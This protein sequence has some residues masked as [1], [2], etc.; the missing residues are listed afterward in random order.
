MSVEVRSILHDS[1]RDRWVRVEARI[2][3]G[4]SLNW[5]ILSGMVLKA[6][7]LY[8]ITREFNGR[9]ILPEEYSNPIRIAIRT[10]YG[11]LILSAK[12]FYSDWIIDEVYVIV[13]L[14]IIDNKCTS[15]GICNSSPI[16]VI[17]KIVPL[18][19]QKA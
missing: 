10:V 4:Q 11:R 7:D 6:T 12:K 14:V 3:V 5:L 15:V 16:E 9:E 19:A 1:V 17:I 18:D 13:M 2:V 8:R